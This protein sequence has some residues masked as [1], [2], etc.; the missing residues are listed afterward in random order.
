MTDE[1]SNTLRRAAGDRPARFTAADI[2]DRVRRRR[3]RRRAGGGLA[4]T[5]L[6]IGAVAVVGPRVGG[7][8]G[9]PVAAGPPS[10]VA[11]CAALDAPASSGPQVEPVIELIRSFTWRPPGADSGG[12]LAVMI[13][14]HPTN[15]MDPEA[16]V[17]G[18]L[19]VS[20]P[21]YVDDLQ[22]LRDAV[23]GWE[24]GAVEVSPGAAAA[25]GEMVDFHTAECDRGDSEAQDAATPVTSTTAT[26]D[27]AA[28]RAEC[29]L[30]AALLAGIA[31][32]SSL[33][34]FMHPDATAGQIDEVASLLADD[35]SVASFVYVDQQAAYDEF[36]ELFADQP[37]MIDAVH[38]A[39]LPTGFRL[40]FQ[41]EASR[42]ELVTRLGEHEA[43]FRVVIGQI[44]RQAT[45]DPTV[46][47]DEELQRRR[48]EAMAALQRQ[49]AAAHALAA[50]AARSDRA[51]G[52]ETSCGFSG[53]GS[54]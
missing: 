42:S 43:V 36:V 9:Q 53:S 31:A 40:T 41:A 21:T 34:V 49:I 24:G 15:P 33:G 1:L 16:M 46:E 32:D 28:R 39:I 52:Q 8:E 29:E 22:V 14:N 2:A 23:D 50:E 48:E 18:L 17:D 6:V 25:A 10:E 30:H 45:D 12:K 4:A 51:A 19:A 44:D 37:D 35:P 3:A 7:D 26:L 54:D 20:P 13:P 38:A 11:L 47:I 5:L 27:G